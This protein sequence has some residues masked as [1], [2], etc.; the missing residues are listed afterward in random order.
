MAVTSPL[1]HVILR[2]TAAIT[3]GSLDPQLPLTLSAPGRAFVHTFMPVTA[4]G[5]G[6][7]SRA[8]FTTLALCL[9]VAATTAV[10]P[11]FAGQERTQSPAPSPPPGGKL[12]LRD[13]TVDGTPVLEVVR[14]SGTTETVMHQVT[15]EE[16]PFGEG[17]CH[18][19]CKRSEHCYGKCLRGS[20]D[21]LLFDES[22]REAFLSANTMPAQNSYWVIFRLDLESGELTRIVHTFGGSIRDV[23][24]SP[25]GRYLSYQASSVHSADEGG[26]N[27][28]VTDLR[29]GVEVHPAE[30]LWKALPPPPE[31]YEWLVDV[32]DYKWR[33]ASTIAFT[34]ETRRTITNPD[35]EPPRGTIRRYYYA[36]D[37]DRLTTGRNQRVIP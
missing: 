34:A 28:F 10:I 36:V 3:E 37:G 9:I 14:V 26:L 30:R 8:R 11:V 24:V 32:K 7:S 15:P 18:I 1:C 22:R 35:A 19:D 31:R 17:D 2:L 33:D 21:V 23:E 5:R 6:P 16:V 29:T 12:E 4:P 27:L 20:L 25:D 13:A